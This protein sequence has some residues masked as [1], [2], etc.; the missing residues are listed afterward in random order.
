MKRER[1]ELNDGCIFE[2]TPLE[3]VEQMR[4]RAI[5]VS[6][7]DVARYVAGCVDRALEADGVQLRVAGLTDTEIARNFVAELRRTGLAK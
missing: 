3:I 2:G 6:D 1:L 5:F 7:Q 4:A